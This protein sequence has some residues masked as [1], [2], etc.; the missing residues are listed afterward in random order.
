MEFIRRFFQPPLGSFFLFGP[1]S[2]GKSTWLKQ[3]FP[4]ALWIDLL[5]PGTYRTYQARPERLMELVRGNRDRSVVV[6]DEVQKVPELLESVHL[7]MEEDKG[8]R[9][10]LTGSSARKLRRGGVN[11][12]AGRAMLSSMHPFMTSEL[13]GRFDMNEALETGLVPVVVAAPDKRH[14]LR[15]Y[16]ALYLKEEVQ[17]EGLTRNI[18]NFARFLEAVSFSHGGVLNVSAVARECQVH[19][20]VVEGYVSILEDLMLAYRIPVFA[21]RARREVA[22][23]PKFYLFDAGVYR[24]LRPAGPLDRPEEIR[25]AALEGLVAQHLRAWNDYGNHGCALHFW[26]TRSGSEV[27]FIVYGESGFW[28]IEVKNTATVRPADLKALSSFV[29]D[30]P[31]CRPL[32]LYGGNE[33]LE[34]NSVLCLPC[35]D[36]LKQ[37][38]PSRLLDAG[39]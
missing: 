31:E 9:F 14:V 26:R 37:L 2:T 35:E 15:S 12:L 13:G 11:L 1:R 5:D 21:R 38:H 3:A 24:S 20:K 29:S 8:R 36:F 6:I 7:L 30:Y 34:R 22:T 27:D 19:R 4:E 39:L 17:A 18:G 10:V 32:F 33:R 28:A 16:A 23:H 25:G